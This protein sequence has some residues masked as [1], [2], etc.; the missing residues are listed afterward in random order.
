MGLIDDARNLLDDASEKLQASNTNEA[1]VFSKYY[2]AN[3]EYR[4]V[5]ISYNIR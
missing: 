2:K 3:T 5:N 1:S 4:K